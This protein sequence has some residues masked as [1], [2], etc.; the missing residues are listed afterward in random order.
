METLAFSVREEL[1]PQITDNTQA[2]KKLTSKLETEIAGRK[3]L[4][5]KY[6]E[7]VN[8]V[9]MLRPRSERLFHAEE[10]AKILQKAHDEMEI[11]L[12]DLILKH[13]QLEVNFKEL[14]EKLAETSDRLVHTNFDLEK[15]HRDA[16]S[17]RGSIQS[18]EGQIVTLNLLLQKQLEAER[19]RVEALS[20]SSTQ[21]EPIVADIAIQT[22]F[23]IPAVSL[24]SYTVCFN[25]LKGMTFVLQMSL[26]INKQRHRYRPRSSEGQIISPS[27][28][29]SASL[30][31]HFLFDKK[32]SEF[33]K[34]LDALRFTPF[35]L[36]YSHRLIL[37]QAWSKQWAAFAV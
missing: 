28:M 8:E 36:L 35:T 12:R 16:R 13:S 37:Y 2:I 24:L 10:R 11:A 27:S 21:C 17:M 22:E 31:E 1:G 9:T 15:Q 25:F 34:G 29:L 4:I 33:E 6:T 32:S 26:A 23:I 20:T 3:L 7:S 19:H 5:Q 30:T 18:Q 14:E